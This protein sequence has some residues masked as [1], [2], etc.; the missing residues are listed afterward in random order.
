MAKPASLRDGTQRDL[1][2]LVSVQT[3]VA[4]GV[5]GG[6]LRVG[7]G[8]G[9]FD[10]MLQLP[11]LLLDLRCQEQ[12]RLGNDLR[13]KKGEGGGGEKKKPFQPS[14]LV[15]MA[16]ECLRAAILTFLWNFVKEWII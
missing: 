16:S 5:H 12:R 8:V 2:L 3:H 1:Y 13:G 11:G 6:L 10:D 15:N 14:P 9:D 7:A 4:L